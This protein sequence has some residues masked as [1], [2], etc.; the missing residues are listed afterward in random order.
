MKVI[1]ILNEKGGVGKTT[2]TT[3]I[4]AGLAILGHRVVLIDADPQANATGSMG[5]E[6]KPAFYDLCVRDASWQQSLT[7]V[8]PDVYSPPDKQAKG[9]LF[10]CTSNNETRNVANSMKSRA[11]IRRRFQEL[12]KIVD[13][14]VVDTSP[15]PSLLNESILVATDFVLIPTDC[16]AFSAL[17]GVPDSIKHVQTAHEAILEVGLNGSRLMGIVPNKYRSKTVGHNEIVNHLRKEYGDLVWEPM[18]QSVVYSDTQLMQQFLFGYAPDS[19]AT[20]EMWR[21][22]KQVEKAAI[23]EQA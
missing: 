3:H 1:T 20:D 23:H 21:V 14:I 9:Q 11:V 16:E 5:L 7:P 19:K 8:H 6:K 4:A 12:K 13:F 17:E 2:L 15:T 18:A 10:V 22:V